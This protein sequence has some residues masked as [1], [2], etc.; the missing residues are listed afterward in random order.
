MRTPIYIIGAGAVGM[1]L[2]VHLT[3][4]GRPVIVVRTTAPNQ[5]YTEW[6]VS[7]CDAVRRKTVRISTVGIQS[8]ETL[9]GFVIVTSKSFANESVSKELMRRSTSAARFVIL[10]NGLGVEKP[11]LKNSF[12]EIYRGVLYLTSQARSLVDYEFKAIAPSALGIVRGSKEGLE[13]Y[14]QQ[15]STNDFPFR[16]VEDIQGEIWRKTIVNCVFN[17]ICPLVDVDN[18]LFARS[19]EASE[20]AQMIVTECVAVAKTQGVLVRADEIIERIQ[21]ISANSTHLISTLQDIRHG[22]ETEIE[23]LNLEVARIGECSTPIVLA[24]KVRMLGELIKLKAQ[25]A[26][27]LKN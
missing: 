3:E 4:T 12:A 20:L 5:P 24:E 22:R 11:F 13:S 27:K 16:I 14:L 18:S 8:V 15:L 25:A 2:A 10:Q 17:S 9:D 1:P 6:D 19:L 23:S 26:Y 21:L 7:V